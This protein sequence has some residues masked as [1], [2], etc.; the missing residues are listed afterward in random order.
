MQKVIDFNSTLTDMKNR[1][2]FTLHPQGEQ[3][4]FSAFTPSSLS[5]SF[6]E[7]KG[8]GVKKLKNLVGF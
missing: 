3:S 2:V 6:S 7:A 4:G 1:P 8:A 5:R